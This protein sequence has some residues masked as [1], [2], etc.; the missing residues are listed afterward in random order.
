MGLRKIGIIE[1]YL[2][3]CMVGRSTRV[4]NRVANIYIT[5]NY[6]Y[7][8]DRTAQQ[9]AHEIRGQVD[10]AP[11]QNTRKDQ[12][13]RK[14]RIKST[15]ARL[16]TAG[17]GLTVPPS[18]SNRS[19]GPVCTIAQNQNTR[20]DQVKRKIRI[21]STRA[22]LCTAG[23]GLTVPPSLSNRSPGPVCT[24]SAGSVSRPRTR[25]QPYV[26]RVRERDKRALRL[27]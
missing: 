6:Y 23:P 22:R 11:N 13:K 7:F 26:P 21:K 9:H 24:P 10:I 20:K 15:R 5:M 16:C 27:S 4:E 17:P 25:L 8:H 19:P 1:L 18:L 14:I 3:C 12:V 2:L